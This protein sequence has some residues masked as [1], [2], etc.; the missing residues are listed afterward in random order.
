MSG[1]FSKII[2]KEK[3]I[4]GSILIVDDE[5]SIQKLMKLLLGN[6]GYEVNCVDSVEDAE[7]NI[8]KVKRKYNLF[9]IDAM[10]IGKSGL[11]LAKRI[12]KN[13]KITKTPILIMSGAIAPSDM[14]RIRE[15]ISNCEVILKPINMD[16]LKAMVER[17]RNGGFIKIKENCN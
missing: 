2:D 5:K 4:N 16:K 9:I 15:E 6:F 10:L 12:R 7:V 3:K 11:V 14:E 1:F 13:P 17:A 8:E